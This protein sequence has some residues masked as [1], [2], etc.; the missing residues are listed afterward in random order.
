MFSNII[1][2]C[3]SGVETVKPNFSYGS[4]GY[5]R[6]VYIRYILC[7]YMFAYI[8]VIQREISE[9]FA[10]FRSGGRSKSKQ[11]V[12]DKHHELYFQMIR[13]LVYT[14]LIYTLCAFAARNNRIELNFTRK[15]MHKR[16]WR[17]KLKIQ[18]FS[19]IFFC[20]TANSFRMTFDIL[21]GVDRIITAA[22]WLERV[23]TEKN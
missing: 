22:F 16:H 3:R 13:F 12:T 5:N 1:S 23:K 6:S 7:S 21:T 9:C 19:W 10:D 14:H 2:G 4:L 18:N 11:Y 17:V 20:H 8:R 15:T